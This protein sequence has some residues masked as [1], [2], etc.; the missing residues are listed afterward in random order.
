ML[1]WVVEVVEV[2]EI[3]GWEGGDSLLCRLGGVLCLA[4]QVSLSGGRQQLSLE[5]FGN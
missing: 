2:G 5:I 4:G 3:S 1:I